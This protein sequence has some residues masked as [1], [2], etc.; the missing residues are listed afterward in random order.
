V[1]LGSA[2]TPVHI[3]R[4]ILYFACEDSAEITG[5][6]LVVDGGYLAA[7]EWDSGTMLDRG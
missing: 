3:A 7:A 6:S 4:A 5:T 2:L 1:P